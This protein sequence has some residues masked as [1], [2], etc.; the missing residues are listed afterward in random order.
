[1]GRRVIKWSKRTIAS[2]DKI[3]EWYSFHLGEGAVVAFLKDL[4]NAAERVADLATGR[5]IMVQTQ[6]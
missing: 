2:R 6:I 5:R 3:A 4:N 1:M